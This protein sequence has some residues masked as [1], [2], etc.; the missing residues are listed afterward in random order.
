ME[1]GRKEEGAGPRDIYSQGQQRTLGLVGEACPTSPAARAVS[2][3]AHKPS[4][5]SRPSKPE[6]DVWVSEFPDLGQP[7]PMFTPLH[8]FTFTEW[9][10]SPGSSAQ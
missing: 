10:Q 9:P 8:P 4:S 1:G 6:L 2:G 3:K 7:G 5:T